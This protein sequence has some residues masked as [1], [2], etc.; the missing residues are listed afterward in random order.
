MKKHSIDLLQPTIPSL[1]LRCN[2][3]IKAGIC[4]DQIRK[5]AEEYQMEPAA[6]IRMLTVLGLKQVV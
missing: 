3:I 6:V 1:D 4:A 5:L 2:V